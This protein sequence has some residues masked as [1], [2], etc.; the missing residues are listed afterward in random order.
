MKKRYN[1]IF[2]IIFYSASVYFGQFFKGL[3]SIFLSGFL[4]PIGRG[5]Y[6]YINLYYQYLQYGSFGIRYST[7]KNLPL[8]YDEG[9][10]N[11]I[12]EYE[13]KS[14]S[15]LFVLQFITSILLSIYVLLFEDSSIK[16]LLLA[17][18][19]SS[20][21]YYVNEFY[22]AI[23]RAEQKINKISEY[24]IYYYSITSIIQVIS[25]Y[26]FKLDG[27]I[28]SLLICNILFY[29]IFFRK[30]NLSNIKIN[31]DINFTK[32]LIKDGFILFINGLTVFTIMS[33]D[34]FFIINFS[35]NKNF[36]LG[37]Y[38]FATMFFGMFQI[39]PTCITEVLF[40]D[41]L[42]KIKK[43]SKE[44]VGK[45]IS[46]SIK[47]ISKVFFIII[48]LAVIGYPI[49]VK[50]FMKEYLN[51]IYLFQIIIIGIYFIAIQSLCSYVLIGLSKKRHVLYISLS[52]LIV[53]LL[54]NFFVIKIIGFGLIQIA[55]ASACTYLLYASLYIAV[56]YC[57]YRDVITN[58]I[59]SL[60][61]DT[62]KIIIL[63][64]FNVTGIF[65]KLINLIFIIDI[66][67]VSTK[68]FKK[69]K[70]DKNMSMEVNCE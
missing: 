59:L 7:D 63:I 69:L 4:G 61:I 21:V 55:I 51:S 49:F 25:V 70:L 27:A 37:L 65:P 45:Y 28:Y 6:S 54:I 15:S 13:I 9:D 43:Q 2:Q 40:P 48:S 19:F 53:S 11:K 46:Q 32:L 60:L 23:Y 36:D 34:K 52:S 5:Q 44:F 26:F 29:I 3:S 1:K 47:I 12:N 31:F 17:T 42:I 35:T 39:L 14:R 64:V 58:F 56:V 41:L 20:L 18:I 8:L 22:K 68:I 30:L 66:L 57:N 24:T 67:F 62:I 16:I 38:T 33:L 50:V 10:R